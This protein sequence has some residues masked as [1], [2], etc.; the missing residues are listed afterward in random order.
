MIN[1]ACQQFTYAGVVIDAIYK[2]ILGV[3]FEIFFG[4]PIS[5]DDDLPYW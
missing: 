5:F 2:I 4:E 1:G 3:L